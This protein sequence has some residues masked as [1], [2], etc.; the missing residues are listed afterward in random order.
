MTIIN[1]FVPCRQII[2]SITNANPG[3]VTTTAPHGYQNGLYVRLVYP[4][5]DGMQQA[6]GIVLLITV[7][8]T[9]TFSIGL[10]TTNFDS[11]ASNSTQQSPQ[12]IPV[13][14]VATTLVN[15]VVNNDNIVP[16]L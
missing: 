14:E 2:Q 5:V 8:S 7:L 15:A 11:F 6:Q 13:G 9:T 10:D 16:E 4:I 3:V 1:Q 12:V